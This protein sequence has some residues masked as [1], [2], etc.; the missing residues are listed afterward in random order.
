MNASRGRAVDVAPT[1]PTA[2]AVLSKQ[3]QG[4]S[5]RGAPDVGQGLVWPLRSDPTEGEEARLAIDY[6]AVLG[7]N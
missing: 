4:P 3:M 7:E 2:M 5:R 6:V 1:G